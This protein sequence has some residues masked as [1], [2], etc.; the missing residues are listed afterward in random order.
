VGR[1][2]W[3]VRAGLGA[4][5]VL[6]A[7]VAAA[8]AVAVGPRPELHLSDGLDWGQAR[9]AN[10]D[11]PSV[12]DTMTASLRL[13][14]GGIGAAGYTRDTV[15]PRPLL[16]GTSTDLTPGLVNG[17]DDAMV[18]VDLPFGVR[19]FGIR[20]ST[21]YVST[22]GW[23]GFGEPGYDYYLDTQVFDF[24][25]LEA[26]VGG[27]YRGVMPYWADL[28]VGDLGPGA[29]SIHMVVAPSGDQFAFQWDVNH[30]ITGG[31]PRR[32]FQVVFTRG[33][34]IRFDYPGTNPEASPGF[35]ALVGMS[36]GA[37]AAS[38]DIASQDTLTVPTTSIRYTPVTPSPGSADAGTVDVS[39]PANSRFK[40]K[41]SSNG[42]VL[43]KKPNADREGLVTCQTP[44]V[45]PGDSALRSVGFEVPGFPESPSNP[46]NFDLTATWSTTG[47]TASD[48]D[49]ANLHT[50]QMPST[51]LNV[52]DVYVAP[53]PP[54]VGQCTR[55]TVNITAGAGLHDPVLR[56]TIPAGVRYASNTESMGCLAMPHTT[57]H[58]CNKGPG[59]GSTAGGTIVCKIPYSGLNSYSGSFVLIPTVAGPGVTTTATASAD[60][61]AEDTDSATSPA[62]IS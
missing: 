6:A 7:L 41:A 34:V 27:F 45:A 60:N 16:D 26:V 39:L 5:V 30:H 32:T 2:G 44:Q 35:G 22:N 11:M 20:Y 59:S 28:D 46:P 53:T 36:E 15:S 31:A 38:V 48:T 50:T 61:A 42:C 18:P 55:W 25:S 33:G 49:E 37:G 29:G 40:P 57:F 62:V 58:G 12:G 54:A 10:G 1:R 4:V 56:F 17:T 8:P 13:G 24:R 47:K 21:A 52:D 23:V 19:F 9:D 51:T 3:L 43:T 14:N